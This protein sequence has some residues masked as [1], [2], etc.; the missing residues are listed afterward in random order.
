MI[1]Y[2]NTTF[3]PKELSELIYD[4]G[5]KDDIAIA[6]WNYDDLIYFGDDNLLDSYA[7]EENR[8]LAVTYQNAFGFIIS[9]LNNVLNNDEDSTWIQV[10]SSKYMVVLTRNGWLLEQYTS[11]GSKINV[12]YNNDALLELLTIYKNLKK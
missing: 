10:N 1:N 3:I 2:F 7:G 11:Y 5:F 12:F 4:L 6:W 9:E 8:P